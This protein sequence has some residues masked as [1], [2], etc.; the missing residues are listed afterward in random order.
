[1]TRIGS[2]RAHIV[3]DEGLPRHV[4]HQK[5]P[6]IPTPVDEPMPIP[7]EL[8]PDAPQPEE[9]FPTAPE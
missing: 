3:P 5:P 2:L 9:D 1:M 7:P 6:H 8:P 4:P